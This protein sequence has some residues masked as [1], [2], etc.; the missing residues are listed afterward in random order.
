MCFLLHMVAQQ[1]ILM[2]RRDIEKKK[3]DVGQCYGGVFTELPF[4]V[5]DGIKASILLPGVSA[6]GGR[7][8]VAHDGSV[9]RVNGLLSR[10]H[11]LHQ[12]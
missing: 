10:A 4:I 3:E 2:Y 12:C 8:V 9:H 7:T 1:Q 11:P 5:S 6:V